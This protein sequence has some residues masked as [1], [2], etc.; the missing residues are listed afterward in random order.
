[1]AFLRRATLVAAPGLIL[2]LLVAALFPVWDRVRAGHAT[3]AR[4]RAQHLGHLLASW[5]TVGGCGAS[6]A[7]GG[8]AGVK[9][10]G[11]NVTGGLFGV[12]TQANYNPLL[13]D[14]MHVEYNFVLSSLITREFTDKWS[15]GVNIPLVYKYLKDPLRQMPRRDIVNSGLGDMS[16]QVTRKLGPI[17]TTALTASL[18]LPTGTH[19]AAYKMKYLRQNQQLGFG[20]VG[21]SLMLD[22][23]LDQTWGL[24]VLGAL[25]AW[26]G[27]ENELSNYRA[28]T[29]TIYSY[30]GYFLGP[31][32]PAIGVAVTGFAGHDRDQSEDEKTALANA[33]LNVSVEWSTDWIAVLLGAS[34]PYQYDGIYKG[35][36]GRPKSPWGLGPWV[37][38]L[39]I[40]VSPF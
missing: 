2:L 32:V 30:A 39:G 9:W 18:V 22:H 33:A 28:P 25:G 38:A 4:S 17:N 37:V 14:P 29:G 8:G 16:L 20:K 10:I 11:R 23:T 3:G 21:G 40:S 12:Q 34:F 13:N 6:A 19:D 7:T 1:M 26:R 24:V 31:F 27:G 35:S 36:E 5:Q 15:A